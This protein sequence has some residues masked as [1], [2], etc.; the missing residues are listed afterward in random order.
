M[1]DAMD[2]ERLIHEHHAVAYRYA[3]RLSGSAADAEDLVQQMFLIAQQKLGQLREAK[4][5]RG[6]LLTI[7]RRCFLKDCR[8]RVEMPASALEMS[9]DEL[10][11]TLA[12]EPFDRERL[13]MALDELPAEFRLVLV[14][15]YFDEASYR[16]IAEELEIPIGT[17]MSRLS[18]AKGRLRDALLAAEDRT[19]GPNFLRAAE[20]SR[21]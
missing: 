13:Q 15:F 10:P 19:Q 4:A 6:W 20:V 18:R 7:L 5:A 2:L 17:V 21:T 9:L 3:F 1:E 14:M 8:R 11:A 12:D 16:E